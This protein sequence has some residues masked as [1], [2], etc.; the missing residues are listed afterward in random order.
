MTSHRPA[1]IITNT[2]GYRGRNSFGRSYINIVA[3]NW[4]SFN[5]TVLLKTV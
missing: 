4:D 5:D 1:E 2:L 3:H